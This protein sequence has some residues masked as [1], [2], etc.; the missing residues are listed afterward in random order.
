M[1]TVGTIV[2]VVVVVIVLVAIA[3]SSVFR[4]SYSE[5]Y[6]TSRRVSRTSRARFAASDL[7]RRVEGMRDGRDL[8]AFY[9]RLTE[10]VAAGTFSPDITT[11]Q[12]ERAKNDPAVLADI[13]RILKRIA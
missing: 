9:A 1:G 2:G 4:R 13:V 12:V 3:R 11:E 10:L 6:A 5:T 8:P 7:L